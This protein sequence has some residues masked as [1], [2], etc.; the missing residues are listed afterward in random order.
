MNCPHCGSQH[1]PGSAFCP[2]TGRA[3]SSA[4]AAS[5]PRGAGA[6]LGDAFELYRGHAKAF[7]AAAAIALVPIYVVHAG[8]AAALLPSRSYTADVDARV[9]RMQRRS[10]ELQRRAQ[11]GTLT[12]EETARVQEE[13]MRDVGAAMG[14]AGSTLAGLG[15]FLLSMVLLIPLSVLGAFFGTAALIPLIEDRTH[16]GSLTPADAWAQVGTRA[17]PLVLTAVMATAAVLVGLFLLV[18]PG[19]VL[20]FLFAFSSPVVMI[21]G[22]SGVAALKRSARLV[23]SNWLPTALVLLALALLSAVASWIGGLFVPERFLFLHTLVRDA[24][25]LVVF[26]LPVIGLVLLFHEARAVASAAPRFSPAPAH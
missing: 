6:V 3:I 4:P 24:V 10:E 16:G 8:L 18:V 9:A 1:G 21:E 26:P 17:V 7:L 15:L 2:M 11:S 12:P 20:G 23:M 5:G 25:S 14:Q 13:I 22:A 19:I